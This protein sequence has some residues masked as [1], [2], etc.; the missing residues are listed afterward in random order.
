MI[1][2]DI[3]PPAEVFKNFLISIWA[4]LWGWSIVKFTRWRV[5]SVDRKGVELDHPMSDWAIQLFVRGT[6]LALLLIIVLW[7]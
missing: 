3:S 6:A 2:V 1:M 7:H 4:V 5:L